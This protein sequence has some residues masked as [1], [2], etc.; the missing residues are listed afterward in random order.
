MDGGALE[1]AEAEE[2]VEKLKINVG[3][4]REKAT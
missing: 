1:L 4:D 2:R 3:E